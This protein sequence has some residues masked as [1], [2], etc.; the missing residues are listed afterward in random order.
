MIT[1]EQIVGLFEKY[2]LIPMTGDYTDHFK[3]DGELVTSA[4]AVG[5]GFIATGVGCE[6]DLVEFWDANPS[7]LVGIELGFDWPLRPR[8]DFNFCYSACIGDQ[9]SPICDQYWEGV[10]I[11]R[12]VRRLLGDRGWAFAGERGYLGQRGQIAHMVQL[13]DD[14][15]PMQSFPVAEILPTE[16]PA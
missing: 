4:C 9:H 3:V 1:A 14:P 16:V 10:L 8:R 12:E 6:T 15:A 11:G 2:R 5:A 13:S 7:V